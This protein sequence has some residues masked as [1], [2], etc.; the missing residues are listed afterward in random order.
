MTAL[1]KLVLLFSLCV[2]STSALSGADSNGTTVYDILSQFG[3]PIG[4]LPS[5]VKGFSLSNDG[6][7]VVELEKPCYLQ[8][9]YLVYYDKK[10]TGTLGYGSISNLDG[11]EV[12]SLFFWFDV[13]GIKVDLPPSDYI[14]FE[15]GL[16]TKKL[17]ITQFQKVQSCRAK[18]CRKSMIVQVLLLLSLSLSLS[19]S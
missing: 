13:D 17:D 14:Y 9:D 3:L 16:I 19:F 6:S 10:I 15:V 7:F 8:F 5:S 11:I 1:L 12:K 2:A 18:G 4:L